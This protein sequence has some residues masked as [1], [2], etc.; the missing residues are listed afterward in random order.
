LFLEK[1]HPCYTDL[2]KLDHL[3]TIANHQDML[4]PLSNELAERAKPV[5]QSVAFFE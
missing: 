4:K 3:G 1:K 2:M 5:N